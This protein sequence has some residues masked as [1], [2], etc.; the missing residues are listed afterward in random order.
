[1]EKKIKVVHYINQFFGQIGG[2]EQAFIEPRISQGSV[3]P[4]LAFA[5]KL[6]DS[7]EIVATIICGD[8][9]IAENQESAV[10]TIV[11]MVKEFEVDMFIA[12]P[13]FNAGRYGPACGAVCKA[14]SEEFN[15]PCVTGMYEENPGAEIYKKDCYIVKTKDSAA[16]MRAS[17]G[18]MTKLINKIVSGVEVDPEVDGYIAKGIKKNIF[19]EKNGA[20]RSV[21]ML[22]AKLRKEEFKTELL[23]SPYEMVDMASP[24][25][26]LKKA[27]IALVSDAGITDKENTNRLESARATKYLELDLSDLSSLEAEKFAS[28]HGGFDT[29]YANTNPEVLMPLGVFRDLQKEGEILDLHE[30]LYSTTGNGTSLANSKKFG[31]EIA[32]KLLDANVQ[33]AILTST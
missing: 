11:D 29:A 24:I 13:A 17:V 19:V 21:E 31:A 16:S 5:A 27:R 4:G 1:M 32:Q 20:A 3:G 7:Y 26:D 2:E 33:G 30:T 10:K 14:I 12:G 22:L 23:L 28:V 9:Y 15:I 8:N 6:G 25:S 18:I